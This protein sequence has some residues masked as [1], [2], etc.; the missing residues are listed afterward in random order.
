LHAELHADFS[1]HCI[2]SGYG[3]WFVDVE[4]YS[5]EPDFLWRPSVKGVILKR[6]VWDENFVV[7]GFANSEEFRHHAVVSIGRNQWLSHRIRGKGLD[8]S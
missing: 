1:A 6:G 5:V 8:V 2:Y 3:F 7:F 4:T